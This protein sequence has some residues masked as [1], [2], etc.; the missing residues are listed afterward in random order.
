M[1]VFVVQLSGIQI[2]Y[3]ECFLQL[4]CIVCM[5]QKWCILY[6]KFSIIFSVEY[7][8][9]D[10]TYKTAL[11]QGKAHRRSI[12]HSNQ[13]CGHKTEAER[14]DASHA[15]LLSAV[16]GNVPCPDRLN[17]EKLLSAFMIAWCNKY[18]FYFLIKYHLST[19]CLFHKLL[20]SINPLPPQVLSAAARCHSFS[21]W[22]HK[23]ALH[24]AVY[25]HL[26][27]ICILDY[28]S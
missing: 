11:F 8:V 3:V 19:F 5:N 9:L 15:V 20:M 10:G 4:S 18:A 21:I 23:F 16:T 27:H 1:F 2:L 25:T 28:L 7:L 6:N 22:A 13:Y 14:T 17:A 24:S 12:K 26:S